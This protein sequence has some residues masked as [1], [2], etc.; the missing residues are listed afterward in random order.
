MPQIEI[1]V[2]G[3]STTVEQGQEQYE[4]FTYK[5][6]RKTKKAYQYDYRSVD[7]ELFSCIKKTLEDCR[8]ERDAW[9]FTR[10]GM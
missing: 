7:G 6:G 2:N 4:T 8:A 10:I 3:I 9:I 5:V 1:T